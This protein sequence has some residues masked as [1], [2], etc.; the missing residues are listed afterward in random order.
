L[1]LGH[2]RVSGWFSATGR[3]GAALPAS[4][5]PSRRQ[6]PHSASLRA[7]PGGGLLRAC[8]RPR[9]Q[10]QVSAQ[11]E[12]APVH[13]E[14]VVVR[15]RDRYPNRARPRPSGRGA[16]KSA[17]VGPGRHSRQGCAASESAYPP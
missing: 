3:P 8:A 2:G 15:A 9:L 1:R 10:R 6:P 14:V 16:Q 12:C 7:S 4:P 5:G 17:T 13:G 11:A